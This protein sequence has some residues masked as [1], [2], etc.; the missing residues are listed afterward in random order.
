MVWSCLATRSLARSLT[1]VQGQVRCRWPLTA[2]PSWVCSAA[3]AAPSV[4]QTV[5]RTGSTRRGPWNW[6]ALETAVW[7]GLP[8]KLRPWRWSSTTARGG[9]S[10][11]VLGRVRICHGWFRAPVSQHPGNRPLEMIG[12]SHLESPPGDNHKLEG[13]VLAQDLLVAQNVQ[14]AE[15]EVMDI[16]EYSV[17]SIQQGLYQ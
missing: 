15:G 16:T 7:E 10:L 14:L 2:G 6:D 1:W 12:K 11:Q 17:P 4:R 13:V 9:H 5:L 3:G 8:T